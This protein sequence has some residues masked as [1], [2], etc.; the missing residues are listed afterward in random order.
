[1]FQ[2]RSFVAAAAFAAAVAP[3]AANAGE[4]IEVQLVDHVTAGFIEQDVFVE[5]Q[6]GS[7]DV[8]RIAADE[9]DAWADATVY[10]SARPQHHDP[11]NPT[12]TG[13]FAA[14]E[15]LGFTMDQWLTASGT[16]TYTCDG[17]MTTIDATFEG[18]VPDAV[19]TLWAFFMPMPATE[20]F[21]TY[22]LPLGARDGSQ[23]VFETDATGAATY[24]ATFKGCM[25]MTGPQL[26]SGIAVNFHSDGNTYGPAPGDFGANAHIQLFGLFPAQETVVAQN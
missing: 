25:Q 19:Y 9:R 26:A 14:G 10:T 6:P 21:S 5:R 24:A 4:A 2:T 18:L 11:M 15:N 23:S 12:N 17:E 16:A 1:M 7:G 8:W 20:P 13:P 3:A 22:D